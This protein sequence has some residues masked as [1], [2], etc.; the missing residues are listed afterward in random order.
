[1]TVA[2]VRRDPTPITHGVDSLPFCTIRERRE[3]WTSRSSTTCSGSPPARD[4]A[5]ALAVYHKIERD[6]ETAIVYEAEQGVESLPERPV[7]EQIGREHV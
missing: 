1:M 2:A 5:E 6:R 4:H 3:K 7:G